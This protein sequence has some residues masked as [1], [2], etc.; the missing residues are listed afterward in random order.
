[1][2]T[3]G[4]EE[5]TLLLVLGCDL[6][7]DYWD[8]DLNSRI[9]SIG[10]DREDGTVELELIHDIFLSDIYQDIDLDSSSY[11]NQTLG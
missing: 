3:D 9:A 11:P 1:M 10:N 6:H 2:L 4:L 5:G 8:M 7:S